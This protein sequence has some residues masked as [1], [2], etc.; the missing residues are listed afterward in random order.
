VVGRHGSKAL[1][2]AFAGRKPGGEEIVVPARTALEDPEG[3]FAFDESDEEEVQA[4]W[5]IRVSKTDLAEPLAEWGVRAP[6]R[7]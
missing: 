1:R 5:W 7:G 2:E 4:C 3:A 6:R